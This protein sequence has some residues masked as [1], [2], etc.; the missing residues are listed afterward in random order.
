MTKRSKN[1]DANLKKANDYSFARYGKT[2]DAAQATADYKYA[3]QKTTQD[4]VK[5]LQSLTGEDGKNTGG[6]L[7]QLSNDLTA[8]GNTPVPKW[9]DIENWAS[10]N[11]GRPEVTNAKATLFAVADEMAKILGGGNATVEG[12]KQAHDIIDSA[13]SQGQGQGAVQEYGQQWQTVRMRWWARMSILTS[14]TGRW[15]TRCNLNR[16]T[17]SFIKGRTTPLTVSNGS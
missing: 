11:V 10:K 16:E 17:R 5:M 1:Y 14:N 15:T 2:F 8:L 7:S 4:T 9:N 6:T 12:Y 13:F 3:N